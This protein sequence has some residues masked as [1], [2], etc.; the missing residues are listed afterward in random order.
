MTAGR[1]P[2]PPVG[3]RIREALAHQ[4][5]VFKDTFPGAIGVRIVECAPGRATGTMEVGPIARHPGG[6][7]HG[8]ALAGFGDS[9]AA[10]ATLAALEPGQDFTTI[11]FKAN[12][13]AGV[14][15]GRLFA[16]AN[17]VHRGGRTMVF[18][19]RVTTDDEE[20]KLVCL[21]VVTQA[22]LQ[23]RGPAAGE[24]RPPEG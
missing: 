2:A 15:A 17:A 10:W 18:E 3:E 9:V 12:F 23:A 6:Y 7:A 24:E 22:I 4:D 11:E 14:R 1:H 21:M 5:V 20:R 19:V 8:G 16:E 13:V